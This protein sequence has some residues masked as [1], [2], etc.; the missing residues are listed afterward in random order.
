MALG[1]L[2]FLSR[3]TPFDGAKPSYRPSRYLDFGSP[4]ATGLSDKNGES[5]WINP[6]SFSGRRKPT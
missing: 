5:L 6:F 4:H 3:R 2:S 1:T